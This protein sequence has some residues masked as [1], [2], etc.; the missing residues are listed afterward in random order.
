MK[1]I[2]PSVSL[3]VNNAINKK[4]WSKIKK[5][6]ADNPDY[7]DHE[8]WLGHIQMLAKIPELEWQRNNK[9]LTFDQAVQ[10]EKFERN[11]GYMRMTQQ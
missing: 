4:R 10:L 6:L 2:A 7:K 8:Y 1:G 9:Q 11:L 3:T 5:I